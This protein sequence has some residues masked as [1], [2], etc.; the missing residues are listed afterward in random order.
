MA[1][2]AALGSGIGTVNMGMLM[3]RTVGTA[4]NIFVGTLVGGVFFI[5]V[6]FVANVNRL[7]RNSM[8]VGRGNFGVKQFYAV[9]GN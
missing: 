8:N 1:V 5:L 2:Q 4:F 7:L 3:G 9:F 6:T